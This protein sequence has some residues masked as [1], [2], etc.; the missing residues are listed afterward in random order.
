M[1]WLQK[2][3]LGKKLSEQLEQKAYVEMNIRYA[4]RNGRL[5]TP[6]DKKETYIKEGYN[7]NDIVFSVIN[8][9]LDKVVLP[10]WG[11]YKVVDETKLKQYQRL[12]S[13]KTISNQQLRQARELKYDAVEPLTSFSLQAGK[14]KELLRY[15][16]EETTFQDHNRGL[17]LYKLL[18]GDYFEWWDTLAMGAN[19]GVP[20]SL[21]C[22]PAHLMNIK[23]TDD[24]PVRAS[25]YE[26]TIWNKEFTR[27]QILHEKYVNPNWDVNGQQLYGFAP[28]RPFLKNL[29]RNNSAKD[30]SAAKFQNGGV[31]EIIYIDDPRIDFASGLQQ[32]QALKVKL[33]EEY[34]GPANQGK[35]AISGVKTG[36]VHLGNSPVELGIID[37]EKWDAIMFCNGYGVPPELLGL[38]Q[39]TYNN[40]KE[41]EKALTTRSAIPLLTSRRNSLNRKL[42]TDGGFK[43]VNIYADYDTECFTELQVDAKEAMEAISMLTMVS[44]NEERQAINMEAC[45]EPEADEKWVKS[46]R[47][48]LSDYQANEVDEA[49]MRE[50]TINSMND[51][52]NTGANGQARNNGQAARQ[53]GKAR[54]PYSKELLS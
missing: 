40:V 43:G 37:S 14:L 38:T 13:L 10:E 54:V 47:T 6:S 8:L 34:S 42:Q 20:N 16:D 21:H 33:A 19:K 41:A 53:N 26:L 9:I 46:G 27:Q 48:P 36:S 15:A 4:I 3:I 49:L 7:K 30:A 12:M 50:A 45:T 5:I 35:M 28:L 39:K 18:V 31:E 11:L 22:L 51:A 23:I 29:T 24:F 2:I 17:F 32:A 52:G 25:S 1:N 44:P